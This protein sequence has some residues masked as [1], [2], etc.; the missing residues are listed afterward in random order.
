MRLASPNLGDP[1]EYVTQY[2]F[3]KN[4]SKLIDS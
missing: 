3:Y 2:A 4:E 1:N